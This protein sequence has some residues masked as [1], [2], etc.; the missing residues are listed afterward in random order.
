MNSKENMK[1]A[2][3]FENPDYIPLLYYGVDHIEFS[4]AVLL[5]VETVKGGLNGRTSEWGYV[6]KDEDTPFILGQVEKP[7]FNS[8]EELH[9]YAPL[10]V[11]KNDRFSEA[12]KY[13]TLYPDRYFIADFVL[14]GFTNMLF[15]RGFNEL[16]MDFYL[17][18]EY[19]ERLADIVFGTEEELIRVCATKGFDAITL[20]D[21]WGSQRSLLVSHEL[22]VNVFKPRYKRQIELAHSLGLD[23]FMHSCGYIMDIIPDLIEIGLDILNPGQPSLNGIQKM[24]EAWRGKICFACPT[25]YQKTGIT[26]SAL[27]IETEVQEYIEY[28]S[29]E[30]GGLF[31][32]VS[33]ELTQLGASNDIQEL[34]LNTWHKYCGKSRETLI[35]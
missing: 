33:A 5:P 12:A 6:W 35:I 13:M 1:C 27:D 8:W 19:V 20:G 32:L 17:E 18:P 11:S 25:N 30:Q 23:V 2:I 4:D 21:D 24:G 31:G 15:I 9:S 22:F 29:N 28:L 34:V 14:S 10:D 7:S 16:M 26:G 3:H